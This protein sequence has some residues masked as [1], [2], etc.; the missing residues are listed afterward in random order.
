MFNSGL[1]ICTYIVMEK[2][3]DIC[4]SH[5]WSGIFLHFSVGL[6]DSEDIVVTYFNRTSFL[7][8]SLVGWCSRN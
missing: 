8:V 6:S 4:S 2:E 3:N 1:C 5:S 7:Y